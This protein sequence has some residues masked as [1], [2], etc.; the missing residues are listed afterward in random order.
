MR[1]IAKKLN[2]RGS[3]TRK[4][5]G[6]RSLLQDKIAETPS[7]LNP[8]NLTEQ[9]VSDLLNIFAVPLKSNEVSKEDKI[10]RI[11]KYINKQNG[12][13]I[14]RDVDLEEM[15]MNKLTNKEL[16]SV[17]K[18]RGVD[19]LSEKESKARILENVTKE[20]VFEGMTRLFT[21]I[22]DD[23]SQDW[24]EDVKDIFEDEEDVHTVMH[25]D[26]HDRGSISNITTL[27]VDFENPKTKDIIEVHFT[28]TYPNRIIL[29]SDISDYLK[30]MTDT[31]IYKFGIY[32][33]RGSGLVYRG[34]QFIKLKN[35]KNDPS[36]ASAYIPL[37]AKLSN[38]KRY[39]NL[40]NYNDFC[41]KYAVTFLKYPQKSNQDRLKQYEDHF[42]EIN[43]R[44]LEFPFKLEKNKQNIQRFEL[45]NPELPP[46]FIYQYLEDGTY[47]NPKLAYASKKD[48]D[49]P[50][51]CISL[52]Y[53]VNEEGESHIVPIKDMSKACLLYTSDAA[54]E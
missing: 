15:P 36:T 40:K 37:P 12:Q 4:K 8:Q 1:E 52:L 26:V 11:I 46:L 28:Q 9:D 14:N 2:I 5:D 34:I 49:D 29:Y 35:S 16:K 41:F 43:W 27:K 45:N 31:M 22:N 19:H 7:L 10:K 30:Y 25:Q 47:D 18:R 48:I 21:I 17:L 13:L 23:I 20:Y 3:T 6:V 50:C 54:D 32:E 44:N 33:G 39:Y 38:T 24:M 42:D 53:Y 51:K